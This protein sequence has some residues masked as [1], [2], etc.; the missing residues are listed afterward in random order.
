MKKLVK[1]S[2]SPKRSTVFVCIGLLAIMV[3]AA[4]GVTAKD[5]TPP[6]LVNPIPEPGSTTENWFF[7][8]TGILDEL[9]GVEKGSITID[10][11]GAPPK[12]KPIIEQSY[13]GKGYI[14][15]VI[16]NAQEKADKITVGVTAFDKA[17]EKNLMEEQ[18]SFFVKTV[19]EDFLLVSTYPENFRNVSY[20]SESGNLRFSWVA[21]LPYDYF[22]MEFSLQDGSSGTMDVSKTSL[23]VAY[24]T[25][26][27]LAE[28][29]SP[30]DWDT[31]VDIGEISWRVAPIDKIGGNALL[32]FSAVSNVTY[33]PDSLPLLACPYHNAL[34]SSM[35]PPTFEWHSLDN[36]LNGYTVVF[37]RLD[38]NNQYTGDFKVYETPVYIRTIPMHI[39]T[40][41]SFENGKWAWTVLGK[42]HDGSF[43][44]YMIQRFQK[45]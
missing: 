8:R 24:S 7:I 30:S 28:D 6:Y 19:S 23:D 1:N 3:F 32:P 36:A 37:A 29:I 12:V 18:W 38:A 16:L 44:D 11:N 45:E 40:W 39:E 2:K 34:L 22:R 15:T 41:K 4:S 5:I 13:E 14:V 25:V 26:S 35:Y 17:P 33:A 43:S 31:L 21:M 9:S 27:F 20:T 42:L 10:I